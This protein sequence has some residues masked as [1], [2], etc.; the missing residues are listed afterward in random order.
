MKN[1]SGFT[2]IEL[3]VTISVFAI[4]ASIA[5]PNILS[6]MSSARVS[7]ASRQVMS[8]IQDARMHAIKENSRTRIEFPAAGNSYVTRKWNRGTNTWNVQTHDL[9]PRVSLT[10]AFGNG[11]VLAFGSN[12]LPNQAG[13]VVLTNNRGTT[14]RVLVNIMGNCRIEN[15]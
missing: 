8:V 15:L 12:G 2:L 11:T 3:I 14:L 5:T 7:S 1:R 13:N 10:S 9:P 6:W 4:L